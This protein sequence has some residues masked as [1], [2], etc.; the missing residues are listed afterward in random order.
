M[1]R[2]SFH[3]LLVA[4]TVNL[5]EDSSDNH[6]PTIIISTKRF[7]HVQASWWWTKAVL[8]LPEWEYGLCIEED[9]DQSCSI[10][11]RMCWLTE[12]DAPGEGPIWLNN[13]MVIL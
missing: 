12:D 3:S 11:S 5:D 13:Y 9:D 1:T 7:V 10:W 4:P 8:P 2:S 6:C